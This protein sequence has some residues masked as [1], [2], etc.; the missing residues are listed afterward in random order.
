MQCAVGGRGLSGHLLLASTRVGSHSSLT[1]SPPRASDIS[2]PCAD[3][4]RQEL[5]ARVATARTP[6][7]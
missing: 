1:Q 7:R 4:F 6:Q 3:L 2:G 5:Q